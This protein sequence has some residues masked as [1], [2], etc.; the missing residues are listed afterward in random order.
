MWFS[1]RCFRDLICVGFFVVVAVVFKV[2]RMDV[3]LYFAMYWVGK[4]YEIL[5]WFLKDLSFYSWLYSGHS[6]KAF[7]GNSI[8]SEMDL[9]LSSHSV[10]SS[11]STRK[12]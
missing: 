1:E 12:K 9:N 4:R 7:L 11:T 2:I 5:S 8:P 3:S 6:M 10:I